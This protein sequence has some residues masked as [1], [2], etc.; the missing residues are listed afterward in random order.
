M[1]FLGNSGNSNCRWRAYPTAKANPA[2]KSKIAKR[3]QRG[4]A[5]KISGVKKIAETRGEISQGATAA[6][7]PVS[8]ESVGTISQAAGLKLTPVVS[9]G[10]A[11]RV[12]MRLSMRCAVQGVENILRGFCVHRGNLE[13]IFE[14]RFFD[15]LDAPKAAQQRPLARTADTRNL[16]EGGKERLLRAQLAVMRNREAVGFIAHSLQEKQ[17][18]GIAPQDHRIALS[19]QK[20]PLLRSFDLAASRRGKHAHLGKTDRFDAFDADLGHRRQRHRQLSP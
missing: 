9:L 14:G 18:V 2:S 1:W 5:S 11:S 20:N 6:A 19:R 4:I 8:S 13:Q 16:I 15:A 12:A 17:R 7:W 10:C 3:R